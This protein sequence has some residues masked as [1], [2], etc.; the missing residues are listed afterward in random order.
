MMF[1]DDTIAAI[2]T[3]IGQGGI[4]IVRLSGPD[5]LKIADRIFRPR[6]AARMPSKVL[7]Y[8]VIYGLL[9]DPADPSP[10]DEVIVSVMRGPHSYTREDILEINGHGGM[11]IIRRI[12][13]I[14]LAEGARLAE[15]GEF[16]KRAFLNGRISLSQAEAVMDL[17]TAKTEESRRIAA[18]QLGGSLAGKLGAIRN[19][20]L[21]LCALAEACID[22][23]EDEIELKTS[24]QMGADLEAVAQELEKLSRTYNEARFFREGLATAIVG[25]PNVGKSSLLNALLARDRAIVTDRP[26]TTRDLIEEYI[27]ISG[28]PVRIIDTAGIRH[29]DET[30]EQE[31]IRRSLRALENADCILAVFDGS[32]PLDAED[33]SLIRKISS[34]NAIIVVN[35]ADL[36]EQIS[37]GDLLPVNSP[38]VRVSTLTGEGI[39]DLKSL[40][41]TTNLKEWKEEREGVVIT[42]LRQKQ[43]ID[44]SVT[45]LGRAAQIL[46]RN[47]PLEILALELRDALEQ[48]GSLT[49]D[50]THEAILDKIFSEFCIGK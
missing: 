48:V 10:V 37:F 44:Q 18:D 1:P 24:E 40:I 28:L 5:A 20:L 45:A 14:V 49:G 30:I 11:V 50:V 16:T 15:P 8:S 46:G 17:I 7:T 34:G 31:G 32:M 47:Q 33:H 38:L 39:D 35:K 9:F 25:R 41:V 42:N 13:E 27:N 23:S 43:A 2:A 36:D 21:D 4:G 22:F 6:N 19:R 12:L 3:P 26:G 29:S